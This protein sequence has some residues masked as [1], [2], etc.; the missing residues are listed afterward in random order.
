MD[1]FNGVFRW[2]PRYMPL[3]VADDH[4]LLLRDGE[5][6]VLA[7][8]AVVE[9]AQIL[10]QGRSLAAHCQSGS[11]RESLALMLHALGTL[12]RQGHV[13]PVTAGDPALPGDDAGNE[14]YALPD[15]AAPVLRQEGKS[16]ID[17]IV[18][19]QGVDHS[20][21]LA[22]ACALPEARPPE[23][24]VVFVDDLLDP[25]LGQIDRQQYAHGR[26]WLVVKPTGETAMLGP[27]FSPQVLGGA[28]WHC[29]AD[30]LLRNQA[31]RAWWQA[32]RGVWPGIPV[33]TD[34]QWVQARL[35]VLQS[36]APLLWLGHEQRIISSDGGARTVVE[37]EVVAR[38]QCLVCG[39]P[40]LLA[41]RQRRPLVLAPASSAPL[42]PSWQALTRSLPAHDTV[43]RLRRHVSPLCGVVSH[44]DRLPALPG[45]SSAQAVYRSGFFKTPKMDETPLTSAALQP[46][47]GRGESDAQAQASALCEAVER[48]AAFYQGDEATVVG[49]ASQL[50]EKLVLPRQLAQAG[51]GDERTPMRWAPA[52]SLT[53]QSRTHLP[54]GFCYAHA[55]AE[56]ARHLGWTSNGC[57][58]GNTLEEAIVHGFLELVERDA[59]AVWWYN[60]VPRP[61]V[62]IDQMG[63]DGRAQVG[64]VLAQGWDHWLLDITH[65]LGVPVVVAV[66]HHRASSR[67]AV[68][69]GCG[70]ELSRACSR[71][72]T[73]L[74]QLIAVDKSVPVPPAE[75]PDEPPR[76][77]RPDVQ[78]PPVVHRAPAQPLCRVDLVNHCVQAAAAQG[79]ETLVLDY[80]RPD[81]PLHTVKVVVPGLCHIW[82]EYFTSRLDEVP[83]KLG[84]LAHG[85]SLDRN[86]QP[87]Y[88]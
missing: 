33:R 74:V 65:D 88:V 60:R 83:R 54:L 85:Q 82:P 45:L 22:W 86:P 31:V 9:L 41:E 5:P 76:F 56:D 46:C 87:L 66:A 73:E 32:R 24:T 23:C 51:Q 26:P 48:Y 62:D 47:L 44:L 53:H 81:L 55:P 29:L 52:W 10:A 70:F 17:L 80:T 37:H 49:A 25:R 61:A 63:A 69:F 30:R 68:G 43:A 2:H 12:A 77:L 27:L 79:L 20:A 57:A 40:E 58:A 71:A 8:P 18:L 78:A 3:P 72:L 42:P 28:C 50:A 64:V 7:S 67:W 1:L 84:W 39:D 16:G 75:Y 36:L 11:G 59:A 13:V 14:T 15:L 19:S 35:Q 34:P 6:L 38:P 4:V 21:A